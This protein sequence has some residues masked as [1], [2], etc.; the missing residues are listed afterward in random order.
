MFVWNS[1]EFAGFDKLSGK[2]PG[3]QAQAKEKSAPSVASVVLVT[4]TKVS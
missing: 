3:E 1:A 4:P 2:V